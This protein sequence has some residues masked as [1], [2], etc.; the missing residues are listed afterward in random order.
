MFRPSFFRLPLPLRRSSHRLSCSMV[1]VLLVAM[2]VST[3][4]HAQDFDIL[5]RGGTVVDGTG[6]ARFTADVAIKGDR[7]VRV[8]VIPSELSAGQVIDATGM[9]VSPGFVDPH[10]H[11]APGIETAELAAAIPVLYQGITTVMINPDGGGPADLRPQVESIR[12][13]GP[14]VNVIPMIGHNGVRKEVMGTDNRSPTISEQ[15]QMEEYVH[16]AMSFGAFGLSTGPFY[17]PGK[18]STTDEI[19]KLAQVAE[20]FPDAFHISHIRDES[21]YDIGVV[22]AVDEVIQITRESGIPGIVTHMKMLGPPVWGKSEEAIELIDRARAE[23][24]E[25]WA[26]QYPYAASGTSLQPALVPGWVQAGGSDAMIGRLNDRSQREIIREEMAANLARRAGPHALMIRKYDPEPSYVG[27]RLDEIADQRLENPLD[28][29]I[30]MLINDG[31]PVISFNMNEYDVRAIMRQSWTMTSSDGGLTLPG[32]RLEHPRS[33][34]AFPR[35]IRRYVLDSGV[36]TLEQAVH[37]ATG[38]PAKVFNIMDRGEL[39]AGAFGDV[40]VFSLE[41]IR[42]TATYTRP[43]SLSEG[44]DYVVVNGKI[45]IDNGEISSGRF[46]RVLLRG[47]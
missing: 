42:D 20:K 1:V 40:L 11:S 21:N 8:G 30:E 34:G 41:R 17:I 16:A 47:D 23:G 18:F 28:T 25:I 46:G 3:N 4:I 19:V 32:V 38:L 26:D 14:G 5:I 13:N 37:S 12:L 36:I 27:M 22:A 44:I 7:I 35:K 31:A 10:S 33:Y 43:E 15:S 45:A 9:I 6:A 24:L 39:R 29:A 2:A